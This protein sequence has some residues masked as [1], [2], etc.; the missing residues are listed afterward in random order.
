MFDLAVI[1]SLQVFVQ[2][3]LQDFELMHPSAKHSFISMFES[4]IVPQAIDVGRKSRND[5]VKSLCMMPTKNSGLW[6]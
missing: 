1:M 2:Q 6:A 3:I 4:I 5:F